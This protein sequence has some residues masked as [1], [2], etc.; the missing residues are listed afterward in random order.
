MCVRKE[1]VW[2]LLRIKRVGREGGLS[3]SIS[4][5]QSCKYVVLH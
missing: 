3:V 1:T 4:G 5:G 2:D